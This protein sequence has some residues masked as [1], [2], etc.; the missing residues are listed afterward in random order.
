MVV[1]SGASLAGDFAGHPA[2]GDSLH[3]ER[4]ELRNDGDG[5][6]RFIGAPGV[7]QQRGLQRQG[8]GIQGIGFESIFVFGEGRI[9][10]ASRRCNLSQLKIAWRA[11]CGAPGG[12][13]KLGVCIVELALRFQG[14][15]EVVEGFTVFRRCVTRGGA[16]ERLAQELFRIGIT[17][18]LDGVD[19]QHG[20]YP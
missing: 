2:L 13:I 14:Q 17:A 19:A 4:I 7:T 6:E 18:G 9:E 1:S 12:F 15:A 20:V 8:A 16:L 11:P 5:G 3:V 10:V